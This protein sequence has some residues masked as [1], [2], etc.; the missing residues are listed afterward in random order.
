[1]YASDSV[2]AKP[3]TKEEVAQLP[4]QEEADWLMDALTGNSASPLHNDK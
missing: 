4:E 1:M 2:V 3:T